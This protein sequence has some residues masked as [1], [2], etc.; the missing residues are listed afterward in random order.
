MRVRGGF[1]MPF[2]DR[3]DAGRRLAAVLQEYRSRN[4]VVI[5]LPRGGVPVAR[6]VAMVLAAPLDVI[7]VRKL[8]VPGHEEL[9][10]G[11]I[12]EDGVVVF[13]ED[14]MRSADATEDEVDAVIERES[15][16]LRRRITQ[17]RATHPATPLKD[18]VVIIVDDGLATGISARA[19]CRVAKQ[20]GAASVAL[21][22]PVAPADWRRRLA[23]E[24]DAFVAVEE[25]DEFMAVG[26]FYED[27]SA[28]EDEEVLRCLT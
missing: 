24:A 13:N 20:R 28:V 22:T 9:G 2:V 3:V 18:R 27:F 19:A 12:A 10:L 1:D 7:V 25:S 11:A 21:A 17:I 26:Q 14:V 16:V 5:G 15:S 23:G 6:E 4:P 8:G